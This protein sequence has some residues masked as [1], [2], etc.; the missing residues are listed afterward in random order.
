MPRF[1]RL[2]SVHELDQ[3]G[4]GSRTGDERVLEQLSG[5]R[6]LLSAMFLQAVTLVTHVT[7]VFLQTP[8]QEIHKISTPPITFG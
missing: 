4:C 8:L 6:S 2:V 1:V 7:G 5:G 3:A